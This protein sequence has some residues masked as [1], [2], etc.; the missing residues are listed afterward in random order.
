MAAVAAPAWQ[1]GAHRQASGPGAGVSRW[2]GSM[3]VGEH[4]YHR[5]FPLIASPRRL[6]PQSP[7]SSVGEQRTLPH[8]SRTPALCRGRVSIP[9][10]VTS[11]HASGHQL[12]VA[13][14]GSGHGAMRGQI[15]TD[16]SI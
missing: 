1:R 13:G 11:S 6:P 2:R 9:C 10:S 14:T 12:P 4:S 3:R 16:L 15:A 7:L 5:P 8:A